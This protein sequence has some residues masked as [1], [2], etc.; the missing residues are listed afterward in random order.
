M[1]KSNLGGGRIGK[2]GCSEFSVL[3]QFDLPASCFK[4]GYYVEQK[5][6]KIFLCKTPAV[7]DWCAKIF[8]CI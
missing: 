8:L 6:L 7:A 2:V 4:S 1:Q 3:L 5:F